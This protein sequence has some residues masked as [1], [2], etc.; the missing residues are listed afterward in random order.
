M[1][2]AAFRH[3]SGMASPM[4]DDDQ[5]SELMEAVLRRM[6]V[7]GCA[8]AHRNHWPIPQCICLCYKSGEIDEPNKWTEACEAVKC[9]CHRESCP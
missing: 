1:P 8:E 5:R 9:L 2:R 7:D 4:P 3:V 6:R